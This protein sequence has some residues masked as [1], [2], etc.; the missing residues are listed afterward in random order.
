M[1]ILR[2]VYHMVEKIESNEYIY[3]IK[4]RNNHHNIE[5]GI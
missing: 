4:F 1:N 5:M 3:H 2:K